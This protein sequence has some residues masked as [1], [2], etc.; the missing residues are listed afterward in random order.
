VDSGFGVSQVANNAALSYMMQTQSV[1]PLTGDTVTMVDD[2]KD[3]TLILSPAG[4]IAS[5]TVVFPSD[6]NSRIGQF[7]CITGNNTVTTMTLTGATFQ[8][9]INSMSPAGFHT[10][11]KIGPGLW[12]R[13]P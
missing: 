9:A 12:R 11:M 13:K 3:R 10:Y 6:A 4:T 2:D 8:G 1:S 7:V 5:L